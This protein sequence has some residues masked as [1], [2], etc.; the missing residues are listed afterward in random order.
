MDCY[1]KFLHSFSCPFDRILSC[2]KQLSDQLQSSKIDLYRASELVQHQKLLFSPFV[3]M[4][5]GI[6]YTVMPLTLLLL[7]LSP[8]N[9]INKIPENE[10]GLLT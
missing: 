7:M 6:D 5:T 10:E 9:T 1:I 4:N 2:T 8:L 3:Q